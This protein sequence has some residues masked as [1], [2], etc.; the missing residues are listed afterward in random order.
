[1]KIA[2]TIMW[3]RQDL[4]LTDNP[5]L[6]HAVARGAPVIALYILDDETPD[7]W[8]AGG[9]SRW[10]LHHSLAALSADIAARGAT[11]ILRRGPAAKV[12]ADVARET[13]ADRVAASR[14][15]EPWAGALEKRL[16]ETLK[17][18][19]VT[20]ARYPGSLLFDPDHV[21]TKT[22]V[23]YKVYTPFWRTVSVSPQRSPVAAPKKIAS[24]AHLPKS[25]RL[26]DWNLLPSK[27]D[28]AGGLREAWTPGELGAAARLD[29]FLESALRDYGTNRNRPDLEGTSRLS[30][31]LHFGEISPVVCWHRANAYAAAHPNVD[32][33]LEVFL[34][35]LVWREFSYHLLHHWPTLPEEPFRPEFARFPWADNDSHLKAWRR[36]QTGYPIVDA[37]MRELW[38]TGWMHNRVRMIVGSFLVK[39][40]LIPWQKGEQWFWDCLVDADLAANAASWQWIA[41][42]G[43]DAA[44]YF[45][46][47]NPQLQGEKFDAQGAYVR[48]WVPEIAKLPDKYLHAPATAPREVLSHCGIAL[49]QTYPLPIVDHGRAR[50][51]A[52]AA[53]ASLKSL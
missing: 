49:G 13:G 18:A 42:C 36:G 7:G 20:F 15:Y 26:D 47:F 16:H 21:R 29:W 30:P 31:H 38:H 17:S 48:R 14:C 28:W 11:L 35:E 34:K 5:A 12:L 52:L 53:F 6:D 50:D 46:V 3:F 32:A 41:G 27:P 33:G 23:P 22:D 8:A 51:A 25:D 4:R 24:P 2:P 39:D 43:A 37:G 1:M 19:A 45:R 44:P 10:W 9:A 40:L